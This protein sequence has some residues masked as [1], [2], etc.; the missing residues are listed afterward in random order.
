M[1]DVLRKQL[2]EAAPDLA[3]LNKD[4]SFYKSLEDVLE[5]TMLRQRPQ[6]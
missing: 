5:A 2:S 4:F 1:A 3:K 6:Q